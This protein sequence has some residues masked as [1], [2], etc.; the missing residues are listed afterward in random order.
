MVGSVHLCEDHLAPFIL[1]HSAQDTLTVKFEQGGACD[2]TECKKV[3][4]FD[5]DVLEPAET[6]PGSEESTEA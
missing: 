2:Y 6:Q 1:A 4:L 3:G 5:V